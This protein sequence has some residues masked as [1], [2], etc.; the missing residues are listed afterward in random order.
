MNMNFLLESKILSHDRHLTVFYHHE[1]EKTVV[2]YFTLKDRVNTF[3]LSSVWISDQPAADLKGFKS[4][5][6]HESF[7]VDSY[8]IVDEQLCLEK[9]LDKKLTITIVKPQNE[10]Q[11]IAVSAD[12]KLSGLRK[13]LQKDRNIPAEYY[14]THNN[15]A[16]KPNEKTLLSFNLGPHPEL[17][18]LPHE[19]KQEAKEEWIGSPLELNLKRIEFVN[20][21]D[22]K[23]VILAES[24]P[25]FR[26]IDKGFN[27]EGICLT[28]RCEA[29]RQK[30]LDKKG[31]DTFYISEGR[32]KAQCPRCNKNL[33]KVVNC[34]FWACIYTVE[35]V[36]ENNEILNETYEAPL[37]K[38][39]TFIEDSEDSLE[40]I[41][42]WKSLKITTR[43]LP[44]KKAAAS[45]KQESCII[46]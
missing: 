17:T 15:I 44:Y 3:V 14:I 38:G 27:L 22:Q 21:K 45:Q 7:L 1:N 2:D 37:D 23:E 13:I 18:I 12:L 26:E 42:R 28:E 24:A 16:L 9:K 10:K 20:F 6:L 39:I 31:F 40:K 30:A 25:K 19:Q 35:G 43:P 29:F 36:L 5:I 11:E 4:L 41:V 46:L 32:F 33:E 34:I 8:A